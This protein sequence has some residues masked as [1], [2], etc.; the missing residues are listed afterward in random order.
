MIKVIIDGEVLTMSE[1]QFNRWLD[2]N[3]NTEFEAYRMQK[4]DRYRSI[5]K[6]KKFGVLIDV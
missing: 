6:I 5:E 4:G 1:N 2:K 3:Y